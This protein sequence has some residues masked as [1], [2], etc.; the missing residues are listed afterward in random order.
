MWETMGKKPNSAS[1]RLILRISVVDNWLFTIQTI[2][3][4]IL[5]VYNLYKGNE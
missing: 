4:T 5:L 1:F 3:D 2:L